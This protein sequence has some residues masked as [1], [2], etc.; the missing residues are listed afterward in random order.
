MH[1]WPCIFP[2]IH[3]D[4][5]DDIICDSAIYADDTT[6]Y[7]KCNLWQQLELASELEYDLQDTVDWGKKWLVDFNAGKAQLVSF[8]C[9]NTGSAVVKMDGW[10]LR[11]I[12]FEDAG[13]GLLF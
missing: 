9:S 6:L 4:L 11:K 7:S 2:T 13:I 12:I 10:F 8:D 3:Y 5:P 1:S